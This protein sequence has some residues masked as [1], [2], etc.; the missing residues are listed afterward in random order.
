MKVEEIEGFP[1]TSFHDYRVA[2]SIGTVRQGVDPLIG[3]TLLLGGACGATRRVFGWILNIA[4][5]ILSLLFIVYSLIWNPWR[6]APVPR[7]WGPGVE[8]SSFIAAC[9]AYI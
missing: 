9:V 1:F 5:W 4:P 6:V 3:M 8:D 2:Y 7:R